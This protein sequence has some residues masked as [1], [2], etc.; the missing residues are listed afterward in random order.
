MA[1]FMTWPCGVKDFKPWCQVTFKIHPSPTSS[2]LWPVMVRVVPQEVATLN[3]PKSLL[4]KRSP[5][6][7]S[8]VVKLTTTCGPPFKVEEM[9]RLLG[10]SSPL[11]MGTPRSL[12]LTV[13][14]KTGRGGRVEFWGE[15]PILGQTCHL[16]QDFCSFL[17]FLLEDMTL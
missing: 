6:S 12:P 14:T 17:A 11:V 15:I 1:L 9:S 7:P 3:T 4:S 16:P 13:V 2:E 10:G 8:R 5:H